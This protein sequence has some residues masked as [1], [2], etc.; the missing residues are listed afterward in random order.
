MRPEGN[1]ACLVRLVHIGTPDAVV[2]VRLYMAVN[3]WGLRPAG[4]LSKASL[5][6]TNL[7]KL[8][9]HTPCRNQDWGVRCV[10]NLS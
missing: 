8:S 4:G 2:I 10:L 1:S 9:C 6:C 3:G 5:D 7:C